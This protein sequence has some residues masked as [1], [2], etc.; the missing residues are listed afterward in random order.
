MMDKV[1]IGIDVSKD[2]VDAHRLPDGAASKFANTRSGLTR[3]IRWIG[4]GSIVARVVFEP[5]GRYHLERERH[6]DTAGLPVMKVNPRQAKR[7]AQ[8]L[9]VRAKTGLTGCGS[10][11]ITAIMRK[12]IVPASALIRNNRYWQASRA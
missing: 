5:T 1:T 10:C 9:G 11:A 12:L 7:F 6:L 3:L 2:H 4:C 8:S